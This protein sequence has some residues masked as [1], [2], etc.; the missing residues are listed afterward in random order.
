MIAYI[1]TLIY[2]IKFKHFQDDPIWESVKFVTSGTIRERGTRDRIIY[3]EKT[4]NN[5]TFTLS[6]DFNTASVKRA[7]NVLFE[8]TGKTFTLEKFKA[9][10]TIVKD[11]KIIKDY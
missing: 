8:Y 9:E 2:E 11:I 4:L 10:H 5:E 1:D 3:I 6:S 7:L